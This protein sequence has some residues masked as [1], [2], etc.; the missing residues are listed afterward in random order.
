MY[1]LPYMQLKFFVDGEC[2]HDEHQPYVSGEYGVVNTIMLATDPNFIPNVKPL[3][4]P[5][6]HMDVDEAFR[7]RVRLKS[8][9]ILCQLTSWLAKKS[10]LL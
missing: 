8:W 5:R 6:P 7:D 10:L 9:A 1:F 4:S 3:I 2:R